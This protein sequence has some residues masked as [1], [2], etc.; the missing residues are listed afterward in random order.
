VVANV[1]PMVA[2]SLAY[3]I[4]GEVMAP[5]QMLGGLLIIA[6]AIISSQS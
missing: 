3:L 6:G 5:W 2:T 4:F 1:E